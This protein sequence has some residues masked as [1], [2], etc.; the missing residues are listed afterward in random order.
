MDK[1]QSLKYYKIIATH[2][3]EPKSQFKVAKLT[4]ELFGNSKLS[5][6]IDWYRKSSQQNYERS[7]LPLAELLEIQNN[8]K[9]AKLWFKLSA[10][11]ENIISQY[12][13]ALIQEKEND[14]ECIKWFERAGSKGH[15]D[16]QNR[17][18]SILVEGSTIMG[19]PKNIKLACEWFKKAAIQGHKP[20]S[21]LFG[22]HFITTNES[23]RFEVASQYLKDVENDYIDCSFYLAQCYENIGISPNIIFEKYLISAKKGHVESQYQ[24]G[25]RYYFGNGNEIDFELSSKWFKKAHNQGHKLSTYYWAIHLEE[26]SF[27]KKK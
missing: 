24:V 12:K 1:S 3:E 22:K 13:L 18:G 20:S 23:N 25:L 4:W 10:E 5:E 19:I 11:K 7:Y 8:L 9:E 6:V 14:S 21:Y 26:G 15:L 16:S 2:R 17:L 27:T